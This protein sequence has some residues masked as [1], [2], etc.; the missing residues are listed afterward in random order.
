[1]SLDWVRKRAREAGRDEPECWRS[2]TASMDCEKRADVSGGRES[3]LERAAGFTEYLIDLTQARGR[4]GKEVSSSSRSTT[5]EVDER[6]TYL[7]DPTP[8]T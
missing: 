2:S 4:R 8:G 7:R 3:R 1:M 5:A 6:T